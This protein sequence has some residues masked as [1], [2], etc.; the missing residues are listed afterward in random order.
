MIGQIKSMGSRRVCL[1][2]GSLSGGAATRAAK[3]RREREGAIEIAS[4]LRRGHTMQHF[5]QHRAQLES[6][7]VCPPLKLLRATLRATVAEVDSA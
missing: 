6:C 5:P 7:I 4:V 1:F 2:P 3:T